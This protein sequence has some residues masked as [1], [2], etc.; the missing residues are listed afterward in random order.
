MKHDQSSTSG[1]ERKR[2]HRAEGDE[3]RHPGGCLE[4][5]GGVRVGR[6]VGG[7]GGVGGELQPCAGLRRGAG[8]RLLWADAGRVGGQV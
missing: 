1:R 8:H 3:P 5:G 6:V 2:S 7:G 4:D